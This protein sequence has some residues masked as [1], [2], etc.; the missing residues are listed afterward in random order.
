MFSLGLVSIS[1]RPLPP[2]DLVNL[3][4]GAGLQK[5]EWGG[6]VHVP[7][8]EIRTAE[9]VRQLTMDA[10]LRSD[11][12]GSYYRLASRAPEQPEWK[13]VR[14]TALAL[15]C[16]TIRVWAGSRSSE[17]TSPLEKTEIFE[18]AERIVE[19]ARAHSLCI[20]LEYHGNTLTDS[21]AST[22][23]LLQGVPGLRT[24][25]QPSPQLS[26]QDR[27]EGLIEILPW[28]EHVHVYEWEPTPEGLLRHPLATGKEE[29]MSYL[30]TLAQ[31]GRDH[32]LMLEFVPGND[33]T[34]L[35][36]E[37]STMKDWLSELT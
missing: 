13:A 19:D 11:T 18:D 2:K 26:R 20:A 22:L 5:I 7:H 3:T 37:A 9:R 31:S 27:S 33:P 14:D 23:E 21:R 36:R 24:F 28:I 16:H 8:G 12:Y 30:Q 15:G 10:G 25:W 29:W 34:L 4:A 35:A 1:F 32:D 6:D 17:K